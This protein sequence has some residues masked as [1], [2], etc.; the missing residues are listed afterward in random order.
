MFQFCEAQQ[1]DWRCMKQNKK[2]T[3]VQKGTN[4][5]IE[6]PSSSCYDTAVCIQ[7]DEA[8]CICLLC[9]VVWSAPSPT[10]DWLKHKRG[11]RLSSLSLACGYANYHLSLSKLTWDCL[12][13]QCLQEMEAGKEGRK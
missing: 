1:Y 7:V 3:L 8:Y 13:I 4:S 10:Q 9:D 6:L 5:K 2:W 12:S 11:Y